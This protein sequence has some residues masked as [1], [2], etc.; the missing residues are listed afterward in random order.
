MKWM[1]LL[2]L[3]RS[4]VSDSLWPHGLQDS[5]LPCPSPFR[6]ACSNSH[7]L[8]QWCHLTLSYFAD[9]FFSCLQSFPAFLMS[10][11]FASGGQN[12]GSSAWAS[13]LPMNIQDWFPLGLTILILQS[14]GLLSLLQ[15]HSSKTSSLQ[16][17][18]FFMVQLSHPYM[19]T[20]KTIA[21]TRWIFAS[22]VMSLLFNKLCRL[23]IAFLPRSKCV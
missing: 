13:V 3:S 8:N 9:P 7:P 15:Y 11:L 4:V 6:R 21:L 1:S 19:T 17:S 23:V 12:I 14:N 5:W 10:W 18:A 2:L 20:R 16:C 22:K